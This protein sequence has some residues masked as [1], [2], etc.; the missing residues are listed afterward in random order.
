MTVRVAKF[1]IQHRPVRNGVAQ[2]GVGGKEVLVAT[3]Q[4]VD[5]RVVQRRVAV[6]VEDAIVVAQEAGKLGT[7]LG[8]EL[9]VEHDD[10]ALGQVVGLDGGWFS[11]AAD[12][13]LEDLLLGVEVE[14]EIDLRSRWRPSM[15]G[16]V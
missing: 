15:S 11:L 10:V 1:R 16:R 12:Q 9:A 7:P 5:F 6:R 14:G 4:Q 3:V 2:I 13:F 8:G